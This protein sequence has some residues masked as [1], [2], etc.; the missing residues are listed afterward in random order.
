MASELFDVLDE[1][2]VFTGRFYQEM[3]RTKNDREKRIGIQAEV[4]EGLLKYL[5]RF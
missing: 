2:G 5:F 4:Y 1:N 3:K